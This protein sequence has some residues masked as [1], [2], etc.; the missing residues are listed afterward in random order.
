MLTVVPLFHR[1]TTT[2]LGNSWTSSWFM[3]IQKISPFIESTNSHQN[4]HWYHQTF[5]FN[6]EYISSHTY[7]LCLHSGIVILECYLLVLPMWNT[8]KSWPIASLWV[9]LWCKIRMGPWNKQ[10]ELTK[11]VSTFLETWLTLPLQKHTPH[12]AWMD[13]VS[14]LV[15]TYGMSVSQ[16]YLFS[17]FVLDTIDTLHSRSFKLE[18]ETSFVSV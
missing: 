17:C 11:M 12:I 15:L 2:G 10:Q 6:W 3:F 18:F 7:C 1:S 5:S 8:Q 13:N 14:A 9:Y 16:S 4:S